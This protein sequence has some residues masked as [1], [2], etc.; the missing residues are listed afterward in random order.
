MAGSGPFGVEEAHER[1][2]TFVENADLAVGTPLLSGAEAGTDVEVG[3]IFAGRLSDEVEGLV[4]RVLFLPPERRGA[5]A[6]YEQR[7]RRA[8]GAGVLMTLVPETVPFMPLMAVR[9]EDPNGFA[10]RLLGPGGLLPLYKEVEFESIAFNRRYRVGYARNADEIWV[11]EL[12]SPTFVDLL[13]ERVPDGCYFEL[14]GGYLLATVDADPT[15]VEGFERIRDFGITVAGRL[16]SEALESEGLSARGPLVDDPEPEGKVGLIARLI[17]GIGRARR[18]S[19]GFNDLLRRHAADRGLELSAGRGFALDHLDLRLPGTP[20]A[21][22]RGALPDGRQ[23]ELLALELAGAQ[24]AMP[25]VYLPLRRNSRRPTFS[26]WPHEGELVLGGIGIEGPSGVSRPPEGTA[27]GSERLLDRYAVL[28]GRGSS[29]SIRRIAD[30]L[31]PGLLRLEG[32]ERVFVGIHAR[33]VLVA[34]RPLPFA[35]W[36]HGHL[37]AFAAEAIEIA[38]PLT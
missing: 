35:K 2:L 27:L 1:G 30:K 38:A 32:D 12:F 13:A 33:G 7:R 9:D 4:M 23:G 28:A 29:K 22:M 17:P 15:T 11:H 10:D 20:R 37:D 25:G 24:A 6:S 31:Q 19:R 34:G 3:P 21:A 18:A 5:N 16:R 26:I 8:R 14:M 36:T